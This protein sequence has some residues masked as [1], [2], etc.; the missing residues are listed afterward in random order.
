MALPELA[1]VSLDALRR[2]SERC[3]IILGSSSPRRRMFMEL[4]GAPFR[5]I[6]AEIKEIVHPYEAP[7]VA[8]MRLAEEKA[9]AVSDSIEKEPDGAINTLVIGSDTIVWHE[10]QALGKPSDQT[11]ARAMLR[12]LSGQTHTVY[13]AVSL[14]LLHR[15]GPL[16]FNGCAKTDVTFNNLTD[17]QISDYVATGDPLDKAGAYGAQEHGAFLVD[18]IVGELD[19]VIGFPRALVDELAGRA[20]QSLLEAE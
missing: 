11:E 8:A 4:S 12:R 7:D 14:L 15:D 5:A 16:V 20:L 10:A 9:R 1:P 6:G 17:Q 13:T 2:L 3:Q 19:T 18:H